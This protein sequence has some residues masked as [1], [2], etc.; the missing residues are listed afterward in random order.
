MIPILYPSTEED[1]ANNGLGIL[2]D[3]VKCTVMEERNGAF[4][5]EIT[6]PLDG[7]HYE[8]IK[9]RCLVMA[10][11]NPIDDPQP[12]RIYRI[13]R[14]L[15]GLITVYAEHIS[16]D[17]SGIPVSPFSASSATE[18]MSKLSTMAAVESPFTFWTDKSTTGS[19]NVASPSST[20]SLLGGSQ[21]SILDIYGGEY[22]WNRYMVRLYNTRGA[23]RGVSIRYGKNLTDIQQDENISNVYTG[24]YPYWVDADGNLKQLPEKIVN[25]PGTYDFIRILPLDLSQEFEEAP[26]EA[27]LNQAAEAYIKSNEIGVPHVSLT[28]SF[29][30]LEQTEEYKGIALLETVLLCDT[31]NVEFSE[32]GVSATAKCVKT[33]YDVLTNRYDSVDIGDARTNIADTIAEQKKEIE[34]APSTTDMWKAIT[35]ATNIITGNNGGYVVLHSSTGSKEP[36]EILIMDTP[37]IQTATKVWRWNKS[38]LGYSSTGYNGPYG[39]AMTA[40][41]SIVAD[42]ITTGILTANLIRAGVL[43]SDDG[44]SYFNLET[45]D[46]RLNGSFYTA[47]VTT[48]AGTY[49]IAIFGNGIRLERKSSSGQWEVGGYM[50]WTYTPGDPDSA[51]TGLS[52]TNMYTQSIDTESIYAIDPNTGST[53]GFKVMWTWDG[54]LGKYVLTNR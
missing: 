12:F 31:V 20:R 22:K 51:G 37:D 54:A 8:D 43:S 40:D 10:K 2:S 52:V 5:L 35:N 44:E 6:Y 9:T 15:N 13:T 18:A 50:Q 16:Y 26:T 24:V 27:E 36:D 45:G 41:G 4:E 29:V 30:Q 49:R 46:I 14:P 21:G 32:L 1:F 11:P 53:S 7:I 39:I 38:G 34:K 42:F 17:L 25:A 33:V 48:V 23:N 47:P 28:V 19:M 3:T